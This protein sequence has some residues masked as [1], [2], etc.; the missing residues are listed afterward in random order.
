[1]YFFFKK[2][3]FKWVGD[4][5]QEKSIPIIFS[6]KS[7]FNDDFLNNSKYFIFILVQLVTEQR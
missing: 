1:M 3:L 2:N 4:F 5:R 6:E 7:I